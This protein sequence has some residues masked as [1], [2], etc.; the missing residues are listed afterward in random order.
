MK[1]ILLG[2]PVLLL[3]MSCKSTKEMDNY[4]GI[5]KEEIITARDELLRT[6]YPRIVDR[7]NG[8][9]LTNFEFDW[10]LSPDQTKMLVTQSRG[11][12]TASIAAQVHPDQEVF[13]EAA[14]H[15]FNFL[16]QVMW[17]QENG[18]FRQYSDDPQDDELDY[19][20]T[21]ANAFAL[22]G[23]AE[24]AKINPS[25]QVLDWV[26][27]ALDWMENQAHDPE[28]L[29]YF[30]LIIQKPAKD[31]PS[32]K[33][34]T[35]RLGW[36]STEWKDQNSSIHILEALT[37]AFQV[38]PSDLVKERLEEMLILVRDK[39]VNSSGHLNLFFT[40][41][42]IP[43]SHA[44]SGR[45]YIIEHLNFDHVSFG[46]D[47]ETAFLLIEASEA[48]YGEVDG[49]T[50]DVA[51]QLVDHSMEHGFDHGYYGLF[52]RGYRFNPDSIE[53]LRREKVWW[54]Q[55][56][57]W[58][59]L[60]LIHK[61]FPEPEYEKAFAAMWNYIQTEMIDREH[62]GWYASGLDENPESKNKRKAHQWKGPYHDGRALIMVANRMME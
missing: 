58:H 60:S 18:G 40:K 25:A 2:L 4:L 32:Y 7:E 22:Y 39:M 36:G 52:D 59:S 19:K 47:I 37:T 11:L 26:Q 21:Y 17:D 14:D 1:L 44:D 8:G 29:G 46:H 45:D 48:L 20:M 55:A 43:I 31:H 6:W 56:E 16:T 23:L 13:K 35:A 53:I 33:E 61:Y 41:D 50:L 15:G 10:T 49:K 24:Y 27:K 28:A 12:W 42:W 57:A 34:I 5:A 62:G 54:A 3:I 9:Y 51:K 38:L 30:N